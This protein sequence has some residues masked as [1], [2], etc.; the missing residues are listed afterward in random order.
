LALHR[1]YQLPISLLQAA[2]V[3]VTVVV[4]LAV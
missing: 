4:V 1:H 2:V 3:V